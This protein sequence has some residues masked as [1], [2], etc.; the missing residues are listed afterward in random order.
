VSERRI[1]CNLYFALDEV[2]FGIKMA[3]IEATF[4]YR[5]KYSY[6][7]MHVAHVWFHRGHITAFEKAVQTA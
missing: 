3:D 7:H 2:S 5:R 6:A 1:T 4:L